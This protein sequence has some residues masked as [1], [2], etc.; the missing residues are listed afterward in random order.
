VHVVREELRGGSGVR[1]AVRTAGPLDAPPIVLVHGWAQSSAVFTAQFSSPLAERFRLIAVDLRGHGESEAPETGYDDPAQWAEDI[2][3]VLDY[4]GRPAVLL[5]WSYGGLV[6]TDYLRVSGQAG[7]AGLV[8]V[9]AITEL[10]RGRRGG[11]IGPAMRAALPDALS[12]DGEVADAA[13]RAFVTG[14]SASKLASRPNALGTALIEDALRVP[15]RV[16]AALFDRDVTSADVLA[17]VTVPTLV[18]HGDADAVVN[19][20]SARFTADTVPG[21][22]LRV[23]EGVGHLPFLERIVQFDELLGEFA[24][25][26]QQVTGGAR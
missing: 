11:R 15:P 19:I 5:G 3:A 23:F 25:E 4:A 7:V 6:I 22:Q 13:M 9:G 16:R 18:V 2:S 20:D 21:A 1:L 8:Y 10:G 12:E 17:A 24:E 14:M 26:C